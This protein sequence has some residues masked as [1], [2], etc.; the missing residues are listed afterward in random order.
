MDSSLEKNLKAD[1][2]EETKSANDNDMPEEIPDQPHSCNKTLQQFEQIFNKT[3]EMKAA[4]R[5]KNHLIE[6]QF[7]D[8]KN[9]L[10]SS[11]EYLLKIK[12]SLEN[13]KFSYQKN[14]IQQQRTLDTGE[15]LEA[16]DK[17]KKDS[18]QQIE[19]IRKKIENLQQR[20][21]VQK[22]TYNFVTESYQ[23][24]FDRV[25]KSLQDIDSGKYSS[26]E[27]KMEK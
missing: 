8:L 5:E 11:S 4:A 18:T 10:N 27:F 2:N 13:L 21:K 25:M 12:N 15:C 9:Q 6:E 17:Q 7:R 20:T 24:A 23:T 3:E 1:L 26:Q 14:V 19:N 22:D 16:Q